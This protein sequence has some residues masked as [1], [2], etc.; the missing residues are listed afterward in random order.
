MTIMITGITVPQTAPAGTLVGY[1]HA[2][3]SGVT[4]ASSFHLGRA[5][6][7]LFA[8]KGN[9]LLTAAT[10]LP[11][12]HYAIKIRALATATSE[13]GRFLIQVTPPIPAPPPPP[14]PPVRPFFPLD[15]R[16]PGQAG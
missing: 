11:L 2:Y 3:N 5:A 13:V 12:G 8:I 14:P 6:N 1:L 15:P 9:H 16:S 10:M 4:L 7:G